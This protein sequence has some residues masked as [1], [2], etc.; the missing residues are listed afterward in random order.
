MKQNK[1]FLLEKINRLSIDLFHYDY[2]DV[3]NHVQ[4]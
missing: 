1:G 4:Q 3:I 2:K